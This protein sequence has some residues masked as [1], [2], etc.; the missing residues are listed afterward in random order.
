[1]LNAR[2]YIPI[3]VFVLLAIALAAGFTLKDPHL[4]PSAMINQPIGAFNLSTLKDPSTHISDADLEGHISLLNV[5]ASWCPS[6]AIEHPE[7]M[8]ISKE[9]RVR[10][11]GVNYHDERDKAI[12]WL[13]EKGDP[14]VFN[15]FDNEGKLG[16]NLGVYGAPETYL[17]DANG[18]IRYRHIGILTREK[19]ETEIKPRVA[20]LAGQQTR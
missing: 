20:I 16:I 1:M 8:R 10:L 12:E 3:V 4:L 11:I 7:M 5:W 9:E 13:R 17:V 18:V 14:Y 2:L 15:I 6:C 19:F